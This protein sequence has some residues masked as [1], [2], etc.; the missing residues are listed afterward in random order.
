MIKKGCAIATVVLLG[1]FG[2][3]LYLLWGRIETVPAIVLSGFGALGLV[4]VVSQVKAVIFGSGDAGELK[5]AEQ[6]LPLEDGREEAVWGPLEPLGATLEAPFSGRPCV[7]YEY[8]AKNPS[9]TDSRGHKRPGGSTLAGFA[10]APSVIRSNRGDVHLLGFSLLNEF[11][12]KVMAHPEDAERAIRYVGS[13]EFTEMG[14]AK[15]GAMLSTMD[16]V[17]ADD[18][19]SVKKDM[20]MK[21]ATAAD[22]AAC[23]LTEKLIAPGETVTAIGLWDAARGGLV[24]KHRGKSVIVR[25]LPGG[26]A[27]MV[28]H[29]QKRPWGVLAFALIWAGFAHAIIWFVLTKAPR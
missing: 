28:A 7:A 15:I 22:L 17:M 29:S 2:G 20:R 10:L 8:N 27:A 25:L 9:L 4:M 11:P 26:G 21:A 5:R 12:E 14:L 18:D 1:L 23:T 13:T 16:D 24:P 3:Y 6:G 19:G